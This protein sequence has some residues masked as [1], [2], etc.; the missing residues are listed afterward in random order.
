MA[1]LFDEKEDEGSHCAYQ[2]WPTRVDEKLLEPTATVYV[3]LLQNV[4]GTLSQILD[5]GDPEVLEC[6]CQAQGI[7]WTAEL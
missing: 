1:I 2:E 3:P 4:W 7:C 5:M 6:D